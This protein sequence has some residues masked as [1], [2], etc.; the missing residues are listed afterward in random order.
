MKKIIIKTEDR[1]ALSC[2]LRSVK[3]PIGAVIFVHG[4]TGNME[5]EVT[6]SKIED[7][8]NKENITTIKFDIRGHGLSQGVPEKDFTISGALKD[9]ESVFNYIQMS[10]IRNISIVANSLGAGIATLFVISNKAII[11][12]LCYINPVL[13]FSN[14]FIHPLSPWMKTNFDKANTE[15]RKNGFIEVGYSK[16]RIGPELYKELGEYNPINILKN[17]ECPTLILQGTNDVVVLPESIS[18]QV[19]EVK[20]KLLN[21]IQIQG[22]D[23]GLYDE[24]YCTEATSI[25]SKFILATLVA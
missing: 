7:F 5:T 1:L 10:G 24:P 11:K 3:H 18:R 16:Y 15:L 12:S 23:H 22:G 17:I 21:V 4:M 13:D 25:S 8:L 20:N 2:Q 19:S 14:S 9:L 6:F